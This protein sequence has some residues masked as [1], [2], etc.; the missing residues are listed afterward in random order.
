MSLYFY[1]Y[2]IWLC[3]RIFV[4]DHVAI[5]SIRLDNWD[6]FNQHVLT[7]FQAWINNF[8][9]QNIHEFFSI[10]LFCLFCCC[11]WLI[12][13]ADLPY[14][15]SNFEDCYG[16]NRLVPSLY[17]VRPCRMRHDDWQLF[18]Q[19]P[20]LMMTSSNGNIFRVTCLLWGEFTG[21]RWIPLTKARDAGVRWFLR[22]VSEETVGQTIEM[23]VIWDTIAPIM[24]PL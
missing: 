18:L 13:V 12:S 1:I 21:D 19:L 3:I 23:S 15:A 14:A 6:P 22:S 9:P 11:F 4:S 7:L 20:I 16:Q 10:A 2:Y 17:K 5:S 24:T 8:I